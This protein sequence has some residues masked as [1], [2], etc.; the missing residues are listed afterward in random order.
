MISSRNCLWLA[1]TEK[2]FIGTMV[3]RLT[4]KAGDTHLENGPEPREAQPQSAAKGSHGL[5]RL[6]P[7]CSHHPC[8]VPAFLAHSCRSHAPGGNMHYSEPTGRK[9]YLPPRHPVGILWRKIRVLMEREDQMMGR[10]QKWQI[11]AM[12]SVPLLASEVDAAPSS[13]PHC[14][15]FS[16]LE[17][18]SWCSGFAETIWCA[19]TSLP[20]L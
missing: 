12:F 19:C 4:R 9:P 13:V 3:H 7:C 18:I 20:F 2:E 10:Q 5:T 16:N 1:W 17:D 8:H 15:H 11:A 6:G 14:V